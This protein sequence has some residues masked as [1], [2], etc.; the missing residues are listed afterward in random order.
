MA[1]KIFDSQ[2]TQ[3]GQ[4]Q[5]H[6]MPH[7]G[8]VHREDLID[9]VE[10]QDTPHWKNKAKMMAFMDEPVTV[11]IASDSNPDAEQII[12][13]GCNGLPQRL[14]RNEPTVIKR[15]YV[16]VLA[17]AKNEFITTPQITDASGNQT[18]K[19]VRTPG[20]K[21]PFRVLKD[22]NPD[23]PVWLERVLAEA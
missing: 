1:G 12:D 11:V 9:I 10:V 7:T 19:I 8:H 13:L 2:E 5:E 21:Y 6:I 22:N 20:L 15:K 14:F 23:G 3:V 4:V 18:T 16:D 17:R